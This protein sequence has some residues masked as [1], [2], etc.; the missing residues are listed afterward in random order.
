M[1]S[2]A[3]LL[4][5]AV[6]QLPAAQQLPAPYATTWFRQS[7]RVVPKPEAAKL[8][9][10]PGFEVT[11]F[12]EGFRNARRMALAPNGDVFVAEGTGEQ[13]TVLRDA[14]RDGI[15][16]VREVFSTELTRPF[17]LGF[18]N[19][20]LYVGNNDEVVRFRYS[21]GQLKADGVP[22]HVVDL[23][24]SDAAL[25]SATARQLGIE[26]SRTRGYNHWTRN[27][28]FSPDGRKLY[29][30]IGSS[31]NA[32]PESDARR[33]AINEYNA[34]GSAHRVFASGLRNPVGLVFH[35]T[36]GALW[37]AVNERDHLGDDLVPD[38][39]T[40]V[41]D[42]GFYGWPYAYIG[43][44]PEPLLNGARPDL[45][46]KAIVP[47]VLLT[48]HAAAL[49]LAFYTGTQFP[50]EYRGDVFVALHGSINRSQLSGYKVVRIPFENG[51]PSG[52]PVDFLSGFI[53]SDNGTDKV[54]WGRPVDV[55]QAADGSLL[56]S[57]D[58]GN[59]IWRIKSSY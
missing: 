25:D 17:G 34:D 32:T 16:E 21:P 57:D 28:A 48:S 24:P 40:S 31:T 45:V 14:D 53:V 44:H 35:P 10:P 2:P 29:V 8:T 36:T 30:A 59:R 13:I 52:P 41:A 12:A 42:G 3:L 20:F 47:D 51:K 38:F 33:A 23:P 6:Q 7:P 58:G 11:V 54:V 49:G 5:L 37:T 27:L 55:L 19:G 39:V 1:T 9:V 18:A 56:I 15:A 4:L 26:V 43:P 50:A 22:E 46:A